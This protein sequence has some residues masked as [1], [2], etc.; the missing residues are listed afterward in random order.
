[1]FEA[2]SK[3]ANVTDYIALFYDFMMYQPY[4]LHDPVI[5]YTILLSETVMFIKIFLDRRRL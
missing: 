4:G 5:D 3:E 1:M 2:C